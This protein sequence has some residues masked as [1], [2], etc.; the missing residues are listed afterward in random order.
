MKIDKTYGRYLNTTMNN[1]KDNKG[2]VIHIE[3]ENNVN[4]QISNSAKKLAHEINKS[5]DTTFCAKVEKIRQ[6]IIDGTYE[7]S[8]TEIAN[9]ILQKMENQRGSEEL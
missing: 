4:V 9:K 8:S 7:V 3:R 1:S 2:R 5:E 6:S